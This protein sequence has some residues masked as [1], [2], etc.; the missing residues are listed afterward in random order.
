MIEFES[1]SLRSKRKGADK[2]CPFTLNL[3]QPPAMKKRR[4]DGDP[5]P[6]MGEIDPKATFRP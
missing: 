2:P 5:T 1:F 3:H 4:G 6:I